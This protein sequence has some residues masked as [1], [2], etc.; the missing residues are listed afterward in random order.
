MPRFILLIVTL[1]VVFSLLSYLLHVLFKKHKYVK[2]LPPV[3]LFGLGA[4]NMYLARISTDGF[5]AL[6]RGLLAF[7]IGVGSLAAILACLI[8]DI[9]IPRIRKQA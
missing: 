8:I 2:Y 4:Y 1:S 3:A 7:M 6:A 9:V 5:G